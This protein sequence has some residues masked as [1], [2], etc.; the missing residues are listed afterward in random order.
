MDGASKTT[1]KPSKGGRAPTQR[2]RL[3]EAMIELAAREGYQ[4]VSV[5]RVSSYAGVSSAT[6]YKQFEGKEDCLLASYRAAAER[7]LA[8]ELPTGSD[9]D[10]ADAARSTLR[11]LAFALQRYPDAG[12]LLF[13][14]TLSGG[15]HLRQ[16]RRAVLRGFEQRV[17]EFLDS[18]PDG[19]YT[20]DV[21]ATAMVGAMRSIVAHYLRIHGEDKLPSLADDAV[22]WIC[23]YAVPAGHEHWSTGPDALLPM[24]VESSLYSTGAAAGRQPRRLPRGRHGLP[25]AV[26]TRSQRTRIIHATAEVMM[27]K[28]YANTTVA[29]IVAAAGVGRDVFYEHFSDKHHAFL[30]AQQHP[31]QHI[32]D[33][34]ATAYFSAREWPERVWNGLASLIRIITENPAMSHLRLIACYEA[35]PDAV[36]RAEEVTRSFTIFLEEGYSY[37]PEAQELPRVC[38]QAIAGAIFEVIQRHVAHRDMV[39]LVRRLPQ[40]T[41]SAIAPFTGAGEAI[42]LVKQLIALHPR[43]EAARSLT[44]SARISSHPGPAVQTPPI[45]PDPV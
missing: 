24:P 36:R 35:G 28:G 3:V 9:G 37:R 6:F 8:E 20:L 23:S 16:T 43:G 19:G 27:A 40:L 18:T 31:T 29:D 2:E 14:E 26:V 34:V 38:S 30:E 32:L 10:W 15:P 45:G 13:V 21:P 5:A 41:Y 22:T 44:T 25:P 7:L 1:S 12:R 11:Q 33:G 39:G 42:R 17:Q 4:R